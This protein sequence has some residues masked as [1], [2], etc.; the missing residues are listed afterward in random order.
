MVAR[1]AP[2]HMNRSWTRAAV[3]PVGV[4]VGSSVAVGEAA[5]VI[6]AVADAVPVGTPVAEGVAVLEAVAVFEAVAVAGAVGSS[7]PVGVNVGVVST[8]GV[9]VGVRV[10]EIS[11]GAAKQTNPFDRMLPKGHCGWGP[12]VGTRVVSQK[13]PGPPTH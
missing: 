4:P 6:V 9:T 10:R 13:S 5:S 7:V 12:L 3:V 1:L 11:C 8:I 2:T